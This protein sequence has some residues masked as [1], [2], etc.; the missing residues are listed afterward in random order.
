MR[1]Y[2]IMMLYRCFNF[3]TCLSN[4]VWQ[5]DWQMFLL[6]HISN[7][8]FFTTHVRCHMVSLVN[9]CFSLTDRCLAWPT[10]VS[11]RHM[12]N[13]TWRLFTDRWFSQM[14]VRQYVWQISTDLCLSTWCLTSGLSGLRTMSTKFDC[15]HNVNIHV[16]TLATNSQMSKSCHHHVDIYDIMSR[17]SLGTTTLVQLGSS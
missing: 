12:S 11:L 4:S 13:A 17:K 1:L 2:R 8:C 15:R 16:N 9:R 14:P 7:R 5:P 6:R 3:L 10:D